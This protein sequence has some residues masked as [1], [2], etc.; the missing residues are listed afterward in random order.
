MGIEWLPAE[1][2][3]APFSVAGGRA[4]GLPSWRLRHPAVDRPTR[5]VRSAAKPATVAERATAFLVALPSDVA[6]SHVTACQLWMLP[7]PKQLEDQVALDVMRPHG[8]PQVR[9]AQC[10][11][12]R[13]LGL[14]EV[15][16]LRGLPVTGLADTWV[17]LGEVLDRGLGL[18]DLV[19]IGDEVATRLAGRPEPGESAAVRSAAGLGRLWTALAARVRP[20]GKVLLAEALELVRA[21]VRSPMETRARLMFRRAGFPEPLVNVPVLDRDGGWLLEGDL[22]WEP[23][24]VVGEYQGSDHASIRRRSYDSS[25]S[26]LAGDDGWTVIEIYAEDVYR[27]QRRVT[28]LNRFARAMGLDPATLDLR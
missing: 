8:R 4:A 7:L 15:R 25:R 9:R 18:D 3:K 11:G 24:K 2:A 5:S 23:E 1:L 19:V 22:V 20:R 13:G 12:H 16:M 14:R 10:R 28:C 21:P 26:A 6:F 17:D 27:P